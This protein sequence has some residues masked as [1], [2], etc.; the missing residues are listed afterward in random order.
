MRSNVTEFSMLIVCDKINPWMRCEHCK[1]VECWHSWYE[2][3]KLIDNEPDGMEPLLVAHMQRSVNLLFKS[4]LSINT[5]RRMSDMSETTETTDP[6]DQCVAFPCILFVSKRNASYHCSVYRYPVCDS[7]TTH[8][9]RLVDG[10]FAAIEFNLI[11][12]VSLFRLLIIY[13]VISIRDW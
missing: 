1:T 6:I 12:V 9:D 10:R 7:C 13:S 4:K 2:R 11:F 5:E 3:Q 8:I